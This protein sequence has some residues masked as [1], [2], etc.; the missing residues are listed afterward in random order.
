MPLERLSQIIYYYLVL[1][2]GA[3]VKLN[4]G[5]AL[6]VIFVATNVSAV[7][8]YNVST[9]VTRANQSSDSYQLSEVGLGVTYFLKEIDLD[10]AQPAFER[11]FLQKANAIDAYYTNSNVDSAYAFIEK[12]NNLELS[13]RFYVNDFSFAIKTTNSDQ[14][15]TS[16]ADTSYSYRLISNFKEFEV[17]Y[18][19][20]PSTLVSYVRSQDKAVNSNTLVVNLPDSVATLNGLKSHTVTALSDSQFLV[21]DLFYNQ[22]KYEQFLSTVNDVYSVNLRYYPEAKYYLELGYATQNGEYKYTTGS[23]VYA[24]AGYAITPRLSVQLKASKF[25]S[26]E[27]ELKTNHTGAQLTGIYRF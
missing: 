12:S 15:T 5:L 14:K 1:I 3:V 10:S 17:G 7:E 2:K 19:V 16:K 22:V 24:G 11:P 21:L 27:S 26:S 8:T 4:N 18:F 23:T 13:G 6:A 20:L 25:N 9:R